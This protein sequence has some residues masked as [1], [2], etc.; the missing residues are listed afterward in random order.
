MKVQHYTIYNQDGDIVDVARHSSEHNAVARFN[1]IVAKEFF[2][3]PKESDD[4]Y[5]WAKLED[6]SFALI[7]YFADHLF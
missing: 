7:T 5:L 1:W 6:G 4:L 2:D 3:D